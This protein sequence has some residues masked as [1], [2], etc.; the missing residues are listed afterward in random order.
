MSSLTCCSWHL[1]GRG[2]L[3]NIRLARIDGISTSISLVSSQRLVR[4][5]VSTTVDHFK[6]SVL[7]VISHYR[8]ILICS[9]LWK[10]FSLRVN[11]LRRDHGIQRLVNCGRIAHVACPFDSTTACVLITI[12]MIHMF[13]V[14]THVVQASTA[15]AS[16]LIWNLP[17]QWGRA[18][19][20]LDCTH[21]CTVWIE[22]TT[23]NIIYRIICC[24]DV[25]YRL[26]NIDH[27][28]RVL[29]KAVHVLGHESV[30]NIN[31]IVRKWC[32]RLPMRR[33][34][35]CVWISN[36][37]LFFQIFELFL[38]YP[39]NSLSDLELT[40]YLLLILS[41]RARLLVST[42]S[43]HLVSTLRYLRLVNYG[44]RRA[45]TIK[46]IFMQVPIARLIARML[47]SWQ[48]G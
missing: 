15:L 18:L 17:A 27:A 48:M 4:V 37:A 22:A 46:Q 3:S 23:A 21:G 11:V 26:G 6:A 19:H 29:L 31:C 1:L 44:W 40:F 24:I 7:A 43:I 28:R 34:F 5:S 45:L 8:T 42:R 39:T 35:S 20:I 9:F 33:Q 47:S 16:W 36:R 14:T 13:Y 25:F 10:L 2:C 32:C 41:S 12:L 38:C 30:C